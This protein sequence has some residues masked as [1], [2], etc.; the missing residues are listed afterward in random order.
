MSRHI[1]DFSS[2]VVAV[3]MES[4]CVWFFF[5]PESLRRA[6][7]RIHHDRESNGHHGWQASHV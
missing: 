1:K 4:L 5:L 6:V 3:S 2:L 7:A